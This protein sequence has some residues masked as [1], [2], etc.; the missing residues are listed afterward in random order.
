M[1]TKNMHDRIRKFTKEHYGEGLR[2]EHNVSLAPI[3][4]VADVSELL[5]EIEVR[6]KR[7]KFV[8]PSC[9]QSTHLTICPDYS[10]SALWCGHCGV[11]FAKPR[12]N[13]GLPASICDALAG[14]NLLWELY[15]EHWNLRG[16]FREAFKDE[17]FQTSFGYFKMSFIEIGSLISDEINDYLLCLQNPN[18]YFNF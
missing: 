2:D 17:G 16:R 9:N 14:W 15:S 4:S 7:G 3:I 10:S 8:C 11:N 13:L 12:D 6:Q 1:Y 5:D 18:L